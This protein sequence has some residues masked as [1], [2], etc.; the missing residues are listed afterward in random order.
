MR[1]LTWAGVNI[2]D[3]YFLKEFLKP[4]GACLLSFLLC[5][6]VYDLYDNIHDFIQAA[7]PLRHILNYYLIL[8]PAWVV[9]I[10]PITLLL[11]LLYAL[12]TMSKHG[13]LTAMRASGLDFFRLMGPYFLIGIC[14]SIQMLALNLAWAPDARYKAKE[15]FEKQTRQAKKEETKMGGVLYRCVSGDR[16]WSLD[17]LDLYE[18]KARGIEITQCNEKR[19]LRKISAASGSYRN[20][21]WTF[22]NVIIY[23]Y[24]KP[25]SDPSSL[26]KLPSWIAREYTEGPQEMVV[27]SK[28]TK[29]MTTRELLQN[30]KYA[31][32]LSVKQRNLF[33]TELHSR[34]ALPLANFVVF[35]IGVPFGV[36]GERRSSFMAV[37][38]ALLFFFAYIMMVEVLLLFS[39]NGVIPAWLAAWLPN[40][41]FAI[42]GVLMIRRIR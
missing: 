42:V 4:F 41:V 18:R 22:Q 7:T 32:R 25:A 8:V 30:L 15:L 28:K 13:E 40:I 16:Y 27:Q 20:G 23:D 33:E 38:N 21:Y 3:R 19:D 36:V 12:S 5:M 39:R 10:M 11:S 2:L 1:R 24:T 9:V 35:L 14:V 6:M 29:R 37:V 26:R 31:A 17:E 34:V